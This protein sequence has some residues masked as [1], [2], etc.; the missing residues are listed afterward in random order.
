ML[1]AFLI[2]F[3]V[4]VVFEFLVGLVMEL[5]LTLRDLPPHHTFSLRFHVRIARV[6][7]VLY[8]RLVALQLVDLLNGV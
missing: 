7:L 4:D 5:I 3:K 1:A 2:N 6:V 8:C